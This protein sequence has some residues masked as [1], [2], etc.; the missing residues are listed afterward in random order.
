MIAVLHASGAIAA[1]TSTAAPAP[2]PG[3]P[4]ATGQ[5]TEKLSIAQI[6][7]RNVAARGGADAWRKI[8]TM[9][10]IGHLES[11]H[12]PMP[13]LGFVLEQ[14]RPNKTRF[15]L[16]AMNTRT[17]RI[18]DGV[19]GWKMRPGAEGKPDVRPYSIE[20]LRFAQSAPGLDGP[21]IDYATK[22]SKVR[23]LGVEDIEGTKAYK[24]DVQLTTGENDQLWLDARNFLELRYDRPAAGPHGQGR[25]VSVLYRG[26]RD[27]DGLRIPAQIETVAGP[28]ATPDRM[29]VERTVLNPPLDAQIFANP[30]ATGA[31]AAAVRPRTP[32][33]SDGRMPLA[34]PANQP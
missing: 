27:V 23:L 5:A 21:L 22:G 9:V 13:S 2:A 19:H 6:I 28:G 20:E 18:F 31:R 25:V 12:A 15:Q 11:E 34:P 3:K 30:A 10:W 8:Q 4:P 16:I 26:Y 29:S 33:V 7:E 17:V 14:A 32:S 1:G 24:L